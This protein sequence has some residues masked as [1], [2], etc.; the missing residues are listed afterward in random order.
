MNESTLAS[1][2]PQRRQ[3]KSYIELTGKTKAQNN[4]ANS[5]RANLSI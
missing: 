3:H 2:N 1:A 4:R 5:Q